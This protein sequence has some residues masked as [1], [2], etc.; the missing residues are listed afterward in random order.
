MQFQWDDAN[1]TKLE[2]AGRGIGPELCEEVASGSPKFYPET[3]SGRSGDFWMIGPDQDERFWTI[4]LVQKGDDLWRP[5][6]GWPS[7][8]RQIRIYLEED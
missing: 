4:V 7:T 3:R 5:I 2:E 8:R 6:S 1:L